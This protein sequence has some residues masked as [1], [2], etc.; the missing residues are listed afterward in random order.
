MFQIKAVLLNFL[1]ICEFRLLLV[2]FLVYVYTMFL[3][4][5]LNKIIF[6]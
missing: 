1:L 6:Y 4:D 2:C 3:L 5:L